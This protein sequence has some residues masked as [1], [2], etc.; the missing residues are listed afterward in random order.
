MIDRTRSL[1][2]PDVGQ[3]MPPR[4]AKLARRLVLAGLARLREGRL[5]VHLPGGESRE[6]G[7]RHA[8]EHAVL[9]VLDDQFFVRVLTHGEVGAGDAYLDGLWRADDLALLVRL[10]V[11]NLEW[12]DLDGPLARVGQLAALV[13]HRLR[14]NSRAGSRENIRT[15]YDLGN[16]FYRLFLDDSMAY[17]CAI[18]ADGDDLARAQLRKFDTLCAKLRLG[19]DDHLLEIG[20]GWGCFAVHAA[21]STGCRVTTVT[22]SRE[23]ERLARDRVALAGLAE[24]VRV[25]FR[26]YRDLRGD[27]TFDKIVSIE[28]FEAVGREYW[29]AFFA[30]CAALLRPDGLLLLQTISIPEQ[31]FARYLRNVD[32]TQK[33][34]FPGAV[35]PSLEAIVHAAGSS[36]DLTVH[37]LEDIGRHYAPTLRAWRERFFARLEAVRAL[38]FDE[39]FIRTWEMYLCFS[40]AAFA[41]RTLSDLQILFTRPKNRTLTW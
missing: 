28:M 21:L 22:V 41:E 30:K 15:H 7:E 13:A 32:W 24:R 11:R 1:A 38:G 35:L 39:R 29:G 17:S 34:I 20:S 8:R 23:Q 18:F 6:L 16:D 25:E 40:E 31:R 4:S 26:D 2:L 9:H 19:P 33:H 14:K 10:F 12:I 37:A 3:L 36:S 5:T 27:G